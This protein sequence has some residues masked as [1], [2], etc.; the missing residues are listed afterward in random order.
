MK[1]LKQNEVY[2]WE[3]KTYLDVIDRVPRFI[4]EVYNKKRPHSSL[5]YLSPE[6]FEKRTESAYQQKTTVSRPSVKL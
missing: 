6:E 4:E 5:N 1:T 2:M 3:Y